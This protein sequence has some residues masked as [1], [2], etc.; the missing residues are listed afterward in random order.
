MYPEIGWEGLSCDMTT[1]KQ[2]L[3]R[4]HTLRAAVS[5]IGAIAALDAATPGPLC[6]LY[7][8]NLTR[9]IKHAQ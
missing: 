1:N 8:I 4:A 2:E 7:A 3:S 9:G 5:L 6:R